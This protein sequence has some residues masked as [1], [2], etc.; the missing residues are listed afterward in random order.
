MHTAVNH[1][2]QRSPPPPPPPPG[3]VENNARTS[4]VLKRPLDDQFT[5]LC[6]LIGAGACYCTVKCMVSM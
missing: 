1:S 6:Q 2:F 4:R 5:T 3:K